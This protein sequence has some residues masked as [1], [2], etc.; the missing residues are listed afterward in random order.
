MS[1]YEGGRLSRR[2]TLD[3]RKADACIVSVRSHSR[4]NLNDSVSGRLGER[5][6]EG[7]QRCQVNAD[8]VP[9][10]AVRPEFVLK[11]GDVAAFVHEP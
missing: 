10:I 2:R 9:E 6:Q 3:E 4:L 11:L 1:T 7:A 8:A 5:C